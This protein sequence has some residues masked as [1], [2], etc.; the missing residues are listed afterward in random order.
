MNGNKIQRKSRKRMQTR[1]N[2]TKYHL[3]GSH[4]PGLVPRNL[5]IS[6][7]CI[8]MVMLCVRQHYFI[9]R[10]TKTEADGDLGHRPCSSPVTY[11][12]GST[13]VPI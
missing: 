13:Y 9:L 3:L 7:Y 5:H 8:L 4:Y 11:T 2:N 6:L 10:M 1:N 12:T